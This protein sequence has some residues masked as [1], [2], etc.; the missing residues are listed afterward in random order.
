MTAAIVPFVQVTFRDYV[1]DV[2]AVRKRVSS[3][4]IS[5]FY[6]IPDDFDIDNTVCLVATGSSSVC[7]VE[8]QNALMVEGETYL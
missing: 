5:S 8:A 4:N 7:T 1:T 3:I 6:Q 2:V